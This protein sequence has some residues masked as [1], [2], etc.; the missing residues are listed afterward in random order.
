MLPSLIITALVVRSLGGYETQ[1]K[2][3][4]IHED[5]RRRA[6]CCS[7]SPLWEQHKLQTCPFCAQHLSTSLRRSGAEL[8]SEVMK[9]HGPLSLPT[10]VAL[11]VCF[12]LPALGISDEERDD[13]LDPL[14]PCKGCT[15]RTLSRTHLF[16]G[17]THLI[18]Q[19]SLDE[20]KEAGGNVH[21]KLG[22]S[23]LLLLVRTE[24][25]VT[26]LVSTWKLKLS[27]PRK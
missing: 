26:A 22:N 9:P 19:K 20:P 14:C 23:Y 27:R 12:P 7:I 1:A 21:L 17:E 13:H 6:S 10:V 11:R 3:D 8:S 16:Q 4:A 2:D 24:S 5:S 25:L 18:K 15:L